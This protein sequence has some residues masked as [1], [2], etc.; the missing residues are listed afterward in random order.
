MLT[1]Q[2]LN[3][4]IGGTIRTHTFGTAPNRV[5]VVTYQSISMFSCTST[6]FSAQAM[7]HE[8]TNNIE[9]HIG[10]KPMCPGWNSG[11]GIM[12]LNNF[13]GTIAAVPNG[14]N[15]PTQWSVLSTQPEA[16]LFASNCTNG[17]C[18]V[19]LQTEIVQFTGEAI[20]SDNIL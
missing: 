11:A 13:D 1:W 16:H 19:I 20:G 15:Y 2:D 14:Y 17:E 12:G 8:T 18:I 9:F 5:F 4:N 10:E 3:P 6:F 7:F